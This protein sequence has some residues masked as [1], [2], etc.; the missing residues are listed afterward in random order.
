MKANSPRPKP[1]LLTR[2]LRFGVADYVNFLTTLYENLPM[3]NI[4][5]YNKALDENS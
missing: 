2:H 1:C 3:T 4:H 5:S